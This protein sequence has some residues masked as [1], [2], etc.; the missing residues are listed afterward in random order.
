[1]PRKRNHGERMPSTKLNDAINRLT[2]GEFA[3]WESLNGDSGREFGYVKLCKWHRGRSPYDPDEEKATFKSYDLNSLRKK[4]L[5]EIQNGMVEL[6]SKLPR[7]LEAIGIRVA[8]DSPSELKAV[9]A[10]ISDSKSHAIRR[11]YFE[12]LQK[13]L[14]FE[15]R[16]ILLLHVGATLRAELRRVKKEIAQSKANISISAEIEY[17]QANYF[18]VVREKF[19]ASGTI[20]VQLVAAYKASE[21]AKIDVSSF[22]GRLCCAKL[23]LDEFFLRLI[24]DV[25]AASA[26]AHRIF[27]R[28]QAESVLNPKDYSL[29]LSRLVRYNSDLGDTEKAVSVVNAFE[30]IATGNAEYEHI[31]LMRHLFSLFFLALETKDES[32]GER[33]VAIF[34]A[35]ERFVLSAQ[36]DPDWLL[37]MIFLMTF[38]L[39]N[40]E[41][42]KAKHVFDAVYRI[43]DQK[44]ALQYR[45]QYMISHLMI[46]FEIGVQKDIQLFAKNYTAFLKTHLPFSAPALE[47]LA[48]LRGNVK[49]PSLAKRPSKE[50]LKLIARFNSRIDS[51][52][53]RLHEFQANEAT[54][55]SLWYGP[56]SQWLISKR[57]ETVND[58]NVAQSP[59]P[60]PKRQ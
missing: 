52:L 35:H 37:I 9:M 23:M 60:H 21:F 59:K 18:D 12:R 46:L 19:N 44:P 55:R 48:F 17:Y 24:G 10:Q 40:H 56:F 42:S 41:I 5:Q 31:Y 26:K 14:A 11:G 4:A 6:R 20:D 3:D 34:E 54:R 27:E 33:A 30:N 7:E 58:Q 25:S 13:L 38:F 15:K 47:V 53:E 32:L 49:I 29:L 1:M 8:T 57:L 22:P 2:D 51:L 43:K 16:V 39:G 28:H 36:E 45:I 50:E